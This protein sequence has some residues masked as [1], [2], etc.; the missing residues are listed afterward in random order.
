M[1]QRVFRSG[2]K[3]ATSPALA[4]Y[5]FKA[6]NA[7]ASFAVTAMLARMSGPA[8]L[9]N[10]SFAV[11][12][13]TLLGII[14][15]HGLDVIMLREVAGDLRQGMTGA[16]RGV[17]R[18]V[19][20]SVAVVVAIITALFVIVASSG[21]L[22]AR[23]E[24]DQAA[25][26]GASI[27]IASV[28]FFRLGL[29]GLRGI[30]RPV[31]GQFWE[32][33]NSFL[34]V[35]VVAGFWSAGA[36]VVALT[37]VLLF[38]VCQLFSVASMWVILRRDVRSWAP[39]DRADGKRLRAAGLPMMTIQASQMFQDWLLFAIVAGSA[40]VAAVGA[41]RVAMQ[42]ILVIALVVTT[43]ETFIAAR[44]A[45]DLRAGR[46]DLVW[47]RHRRAT[48]AMGL[49]IGPLVLVCILFPEQL[50]GLAFGPAFVIAGPALAI[51]ATGQATKIAT[52]PIGGLLT[53]AGYERW[54]LSFT[55]IGL[56]LLVGLS[57]TLVPIWGL[58]GAAVAQ[59]VS[60]GFRNIA[61]FTAAW[62]L[63][64]KEPPSSKA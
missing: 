31:A 7:A 61:S 55:F 57:L 59:A 22:S 20:G 24:T 35:G 49:A 30:G 13:A 29:A 21:Q 45:G 6:A 27:G 2:R 51:M 4:A 14:A 38:F 17:I 1:R 10:F 43:G 62:F 32:G 40:S 28:A 16:A 15:M 25:M 12:S 63:I 26:I 60:T 47:R 53:M 18:F 11:L 34:F 42:I 33:A 3:L 50:L 39:P 48:L 8:I 23:L 5:G 64:P 9:G 52:G 54:L 19:I 44:V 46:P 37:A 56:L 58:A 36:P 41:L